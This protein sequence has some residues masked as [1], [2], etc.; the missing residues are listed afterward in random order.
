MSQELMNLIWGKRETLLLSRA[1]MTVLIRL[2]DFSAGGD[3]TGVFSRLVK[4]TGCSRSTVKRSLNRLRLKNV[5]P[6]KA[7]RNLPRQDN[8]HYKINVEVFSS[9]SQEGD[10]E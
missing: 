4:E 6:D 5:L 2:A 7:G 10:A 9:R 8:T 3:Q 1:E